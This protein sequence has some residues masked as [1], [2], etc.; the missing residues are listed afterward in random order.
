MAEIQSN[1][2]KPDEPVKQQPATDGGW[3]PWGTSEKQKF[4]QAD[5][6]GHTQQL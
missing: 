5:G 2:E 3:E 4:G 6:S 1:K